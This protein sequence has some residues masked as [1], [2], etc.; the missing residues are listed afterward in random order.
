MK[1]YHEMA[2]DVFRRAEEERQAIRRKHRVAAATGIPVL[3]T[4]LALAI[5]FWPKASQSPQTDP[6]HLDQSQS[7]VMSKPNMTEPTVSFGQLPE[8]QT[9]QSTYSPQTQ[10]DALLHIPA[11]ELPE[12]VDNVELDM[13]GLVVY[14]GGIYTQAADY[15]RSDAEALRG[16]V[17]TFLGRAVG[18]IDEWT[19]QDEYAEEF[20][21]TLVGDVYTVNGYSPDFRICVVAETLDADGTPIQWMQILER[22]NGIDVSTGADLYANRLHMEGRITGIRCQSFEDWDNAR[23][24]FRPLEAADSMDAFLEALNDGELQYVYEDDHYFYRNTRSQA[25]LYLE[26]DDGTAIPLRL[27]EGGWVGYGPM[28]WYFVQLPTEVFDPVFEAAGRQ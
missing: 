21:S 12:P 27:I 20:A 6:V 23:T 2:N 10:T 17:G 4:A 5:T 1:N 3:C 24:I 7:A 26:L 9:N 11:I 14:K 15:Y 8:T 28:P 18:N 13:I 25:F 19:S 16:L 22:L